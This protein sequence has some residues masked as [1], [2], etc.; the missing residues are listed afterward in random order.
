MI[1]A[2]SVN[3]QPIPELLDFLASKFRDD[4][5]SIKRMIRGI[6]LS[7]TYQMSSEFDVES[8]KQD[9]KNL[10]W[11]HVPPKRL[12]GEAIR[13]AMLLFSG[14]LKPELYGPSVPIHLTDFMDGRGRPKKSGP[15]DGAGRRSIYVSVRRN[16]LSP[17]MLAFDTPSPFSTMGRQCFECSRPGFDLDERIRWVVKQAEA[18]AVR[19]LK[20][21]SLT[22]E[23]RVGWLYGMAFSPPPHAD[24]LAL[25]MAFIQQ[26]N[27]DTHP[28]TPSPLRRGEGERGSRDVSGSSTSAWVALAH[29]LINT[30]EF[31]FL[32]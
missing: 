29:A 24:E 22:I 21:S 15:S 23:E 32:R 2:F 16:F 4:G 12:E 11:H 20:K 13:D 17:F 14:N 10:L 1:L 6:V 5:Q 3:F 18:F 27:D 25:A 31:I 26:Y 7:Q 9:P 30:K 28:S 8:A 19:A